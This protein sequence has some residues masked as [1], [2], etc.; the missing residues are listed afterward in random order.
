MKAFVRVHQAFK[1]EPF[2]S[3]AVTSSS[4]SEKSKAFIAAKWWVHI[5]DRYAEYTQPGSELFCILSLGLHIVLHIYAK[6]CQC[7]YMQNNTK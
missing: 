6:T 5:Y 4:D 3:L 1:L 2:D 7:L